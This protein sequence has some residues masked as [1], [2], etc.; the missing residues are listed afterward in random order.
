MREEPH[1]LY[2][3]MRELYGNVV[4][5]TLSGVPAWLVI[6]YAEI[7]E[8]VGG[9][10][11]AFSR[12][13]GLWRERDQLPED[14]PLEL[15]T[16]PMK[17]A[18]FA[19]G[20]EH[21]RLRG[22][23]AESLTRTSTARVIRYTTDTAHH[24]IDGFCEAGQADLVAQYAAPLPLLV[25]MRLFGFPLAD[26]ELLLSQIPALLEGGEEAAEADRQ[27]Q[28][29]IG[30]HVDRR[31]VEP[32]ADAMSWLIS[33]EAALN[34]EEIRA[35]VWLALNAGMPSASNWIANTLEQL[36]TTLKMQQELLAGWM[37]IEGVM[38]RTLWE[39]PPV[40]NVLG[41]IAVRDV[42]LG[43]A[44]IQRGELLIL[45][46]AAAN[47]DPRLNSPSQP[48]GS[49]TGHN[50]S[51]LAW[52][53]G[54]HEC[55]VPTLAHTIVRCAVESLSER[56]PVMTLADPYGP[57]NWGPSIIVRALHSLSVS[58]TPRAPRSRTRPTSA[59]GS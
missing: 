41:R 34:D 42:R 58:F 2:R 26:G 15:H 40:Q 57:Q 54:A 27:I 10:P 45:G 14:W 56:L 53:A 31:R 43:K 47:I 28:A 48:R 24:L 59:G 22:A 25:L 17:N 50:D 6:G 3:R 29:I 21:R 49:Y 51:H 30:A 18:L 44:D 39:R 16:R 19:S 23:L 32:A 37:A 11:Y 20:G 12:D 7:K 9:E 13:L 36:V 52:G 1:E 55:P 33:S 35:Q 5:V 4:P 8:V 46:L 38:Q